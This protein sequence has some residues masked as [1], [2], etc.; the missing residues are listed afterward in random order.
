MGYKCV[1]RC[2]PSMSSVEQLLTGFW[3]LP[4]VCCEDAGGLFH[5]AMDT[6]TNAPTQAQFAVIVGHQR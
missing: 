2:R 4:G 6:H 1:V 5:L 3:D